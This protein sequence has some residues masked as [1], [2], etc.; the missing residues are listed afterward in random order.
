MITKLIGYTDK[1]DKAV[2]DN[3]DNWDNEEILD[4]L[5]KIVPNPTLADV[6]GMT[7]GMAYGLSL[8][9]LITVIDEDNCDELLR[10]AFKSMIKF[11]EDNGVTWFDKRD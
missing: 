8:E 9:D 6:I 4:Y 10:N 3:I 1:Y 5:D 2:R 7:I 11:V